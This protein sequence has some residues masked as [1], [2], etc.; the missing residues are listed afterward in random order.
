MNSEP[1]VCILTS[2]VRCPV[3]PKSKAYLPRVI[4]GQAAGSTAIA[5]TFALVAQ[6]LADKGK[7]D[8]GEVGAAAGATDHDVGIGVGLFHLLDRLEADDRLVHEHVIEDAAESVFRVG[9]LG[10]DFDGF[11]DR[12]AEASRRIRMRLKNGAPRI[13]FVARARHA[14]SRRRSP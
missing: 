2:G 11:R 10:R 3:S 1:S 8:A 13:R 9:V 12:D 14:V 4:D 7:R 6:L 5:R